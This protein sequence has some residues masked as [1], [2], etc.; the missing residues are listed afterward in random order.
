MKRRLDCDF[1]LQNKKRKIQQNDEIQ[2]F[3]LQQQKIIEN[4][5][6]IIYELN[7][8]INDNQKKISILEDQL[9]RIIPEPIP[10][11]SSPPSYIS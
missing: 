2:Q 10:F 7:G 9:R 6:N 8:K 5:Q 11:D 3:L 4:Y 1:N